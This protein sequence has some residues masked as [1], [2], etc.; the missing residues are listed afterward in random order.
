MTRSFFGRRIRLPFPPYWSTSVAF[1]IFLGVFLVLPFSFRGAKLA[2]RDMKNNVKDWL[3]ADFPETRELE[4][5]RDQ[6]L[7]DVFV[8]VSWQG[9]TADDQRLSLLAKK[10]VP[11]DIDTRHAGEV[12]TAEDPLP[13]KPSVFVGDQFGLFL[14]TVEE[15]GKYRTEDYFNW[16]NL[17]EKWLLGDNSLWY[18]ITPDGKLYRWDKSNTLPQVIKD[19]I[20]KRWSGHNTASGEHVATLDT[21]YYR[22][23]R[24]LEA[25][26][27]KKVVTGPQVLEQLV[28]EGGSLRRGV[29]DD[30]EALK[31]ARKVALERLEGALYG[32]NGKQ[33]CLIVTLTE[34][35]RRDLN[36]VAGHGIYGKPRGKIL[37]YAEEAGIDSDTLAMGGPPVDN[38]AIDEEGTRTLMRLVAFSAIVGLTLAYLSFKSVK[39]T[40]MIFFVGAVS[41]VT[42]L[43]IVFWGGGVM[44]AILMSM[45]SLIYVL[46]LSGAV[47]MINYYRDA[48][49]EDGL[50][51]APDTA[52]KH[53][54][55]PCTL[56]AIT[57]S[58]GLLSL[59]TSQLTPIR[60]FG[61]YSALGVMAT[62]FFLYTYLPAALQLWPSGFRMRDGK[63]T[64]EDSKLSQAMERF[65]SAVCAFVLR[66]NGKVVVA[67][68]LVLVVFA[69]GL[70]R[71]KTEVQLLKLF[72]PQA[73]IIKDYHWLENVLG[74]L[75]PMEIVLCVQ[76][77]E[78][79]P[80]ATWR[81]A[82][83]E[84]DRSAEP[85]QL[86]FLERMEMVDHVQRILEREFGGRH[87]VVGRSMSA[88]TFAPVL[89]AAGKSSQQFTERGAFDRKLEEHRGELLDS[90]Y[91]RNDSGND[92]ELWRISLRLG[93]FTD[94]DYGLFVDQFKAAVEPA[95]SA[96]R[97][98]PQVLRE[99][100]AARGGKRHLKAKVLILGASTGVLEE[101]PEAGGMKSE[102]PAQSRFN[103]DQALAQQIDQTRI[104]SETLLELLTNARCRAAAHDPHRAP[105]DG[106]SEESRGWSNMLTDPEKLKTIDCIVLASDDPGYDLELIRKHVGLV[107]D[108]RD[109]RYQP[110]KNAPSAAQ[111]SKQ[112]ETNVFAIYTGVVPVVYKAQRTL[113]YSLRDSTF[114]SFALIFLVMAFLLRGG[115]R[116][117]RSQ[118]PNFPGGLLSMAPNIFPLIVIFGGMGLLGISVDI[119]SMMTASV[120]M[121][122]AVDDTI[123]FLNWFRLGLNEGL[124]RKQA[125]TMA[126]KRVSVAMTQTTAIGGLGL[127]V[128]AFSTF[129][130]TQRFGTLMLALLVAALVGDLIFLPAILA[131][132][133]GAVFR[134][135]KKKDDAGSDPST[136]ILDTHESPSSGEVA[137]VK[138]GESGGVA[139]GNGESPATAP[140]L[141]PDRAHPKANN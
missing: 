123:H 45:P 7:G 58:V 8:V 89:P 79:L 56:A 114:L 44:D 17:E 83:R 88:A 139:S 9:C 32:K 112:G 27:F 106:D 93:A 115:R 86:N 37:L 107:I 62:L 14:D 77:D 85:F 68:C 108:A 18:Y 48:I 127:A 29:G 41:G 103:T 118:F 121:G 20:E 61:L 60:K 21:K 34:V 50:E 136:M 135:S 92:D 57:T 100:V 130:P 109:H 4:W 132:P 69:L 23:V 43:S 52:L 10:L 75:I 111:R 110:E 59:Y 102:T 5:F 63:P 51:G 120:A 31:E 94:L 1:I 11:D 98:R 42:S 67:C 22:N 80:P 54:W 47:H 141:R 6:F 116:G 15:N 73:Q 16:G 66:N 105:L 33:T 87:D 82:H 134:G 128:F 38:V 24:L 65:W 96:Y 133:L 40:I 74:K 91:L 90:D 72:S 26:F 99:I 46:G 101:A 81:D 35:G 19:S 125:I 78:M 70:S 28:G 55:W 13:L 119:G 12:S 39:L 129:T 104:F 126:Y 97:Y 30:P 95:M 71:I 3:P 124:E 49:R 140:H 36:R 53:A 64:I 131:S 84:R 138:D 117:W 25:Q 122:V 113:L 76:P 137:T 2:L